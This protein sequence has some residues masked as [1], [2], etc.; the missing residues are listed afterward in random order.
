VEAI[1]RFL[2]KPL[3][4]HRSTQ[5]HIRS[6]LHRRHLP[7]NR[8]VKKQ[9]YVPKG[10]FIFKNEK[11]TAPGILCVENYLGKKIWVLA[12]PGPPREL[13]PVFEEKALPRFLREN[14]TPQEHF[15]VRTIKITGITE[16][17]VAVKVT[18]L[19]K[20]KPPATVG[21][22]AKPGEVELKIMA[23]NTPLSK[24]RAEVTRIERTIRKRLGR[25]IYGVDHDTLASVIGK[26]LREKKKTLAIAES[27]TGGLV[28]YLVTEVP[29]SSEYLTGS[30]VAYSNRIK[31]SKLEIPPG[32]L[33]KHGAVSRQSAL[34]M[35][36]NVRRLFGS[37]YGIAV[38]GIA[39]PGGGSRSKPVGLVYTSVADKNKT[40]CFK[41]NFFGARGEIKAEAAQKTLDLFRLFLL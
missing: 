18:D 23:K 4:L 14:R 2:K 38:T 9:C 5:Q 17:Q 33:A 41:N 31:V 12:L 30:V 7:F 20:L 16:A 21:I 19:L 26:S 32:L 8:L 6:V 11:G 29:G 34:G 40:V 1:S 39:G 28:S 13:E 27:C 25:K 15:L 10:A 35:A 37:D 3:F 22:Y 24:A 36:Q